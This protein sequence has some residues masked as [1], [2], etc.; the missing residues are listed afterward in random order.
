MAIEVKALSGDVSLPTPASQAA[1]QLF[2]AG[3][4]SFRAETQDVLSGL[5]WKLVRALQGINGNNRAGNTP[6]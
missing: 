2:H 3:E 1:R 6:G 5:I 4:N